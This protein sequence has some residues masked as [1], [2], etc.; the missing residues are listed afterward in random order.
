MALRV[1]LIQGGEIGHDLVPAV[2]RVLAEAGVSIEW[3]EHVAGFEAVKQGLPPLPAAMLDSVRRTGLAL[4]TKLMPDPAKPRTNYNV[5]LRRTLQ[6]FATVRPLKNLRGLKARFSNVDMLV[7]R[8]ITEDLYAAIEH[9]IVPGVVQSLKIV[10]DKASR[11]F[12]EFAFRWALDAGRKLVTCVHKANILKMAD[13]LFL[14]AFRDVARQYPQLQTK[15][16]IVDN[17]CM[18]MVS[19][20]QQ[21]DVLVMGNLYGDIVSDLGAGVVGGI[22]AT[23]GIN[24][25]DGIRCFECFHGAGRERVGVD[26]ANP[27]PLLLPAADLLE[28]VGQKEAASRILQAMEHVLAETSVRTPDLG[29]T[30][31]TTAMTEA[32]LRGLA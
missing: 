30:A 5:E 20:P 8:E 15:E 12:F 22:S 27:L 1:T 17:C 3:D 29:G 28:G 7:F 26:R 31:T 6:L 11:R 4:K 32:I 16:L 18:Q 21:F 25:G 24:V 2:K 9:E 14:E 23:A 13:G 10:T 19:K